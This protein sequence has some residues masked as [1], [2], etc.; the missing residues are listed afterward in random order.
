M[1]FFG[2]EINRFHLEITTNCVLHCPACQRTGK[3]DLPLI[4]WDL[5]LVQK[6]F[7]VE[8]KKHFI[9]KI[10]T[11]SGTY[12]DPIYNPHLLKILGYLK[13]LGFKIQLE[14]NGSHRQRSFWY[15]LAD[16]LGPE[17]EIVFSGALARI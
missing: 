8:Y 3:A 12:G 4:N 2:K 11:L 17:D 16:T 14:T 15:S 10:V 7:P 13:D 1:N 5:E 9:K 6:L